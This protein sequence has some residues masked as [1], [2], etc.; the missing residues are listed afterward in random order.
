MDRN[1]PMPRSVFQEGFIHQ[2][3][4]P[5]YKTLNAVEGLDFSVQVQAFENMARHWVGD[6]SKPKPNKLKETRSFSL[7]KK[8]S[9]PA[10]AYKS[11]R[12][13]YENEVEEEYDETETKEMGNQGA[14]RSVSHDGTVQSS[15]SDVRHRLNLSP[16]AFLSEGQDHMDDI[17]NG[18]QRSAIRDAILRSRAAKASAFQPVMTTSFNRAFSS[19]LMS[20][21]LLASP[22]P[23]SDAQGARKAMM[24][25]EEEAE[26]YLATRRRKR[27]AG[28]PSTEKHQQ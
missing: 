13:M 5:L 21:P 18:V 23:P 14:I 27:P 16:R 10:D 4:L 20:S 26:D 25:E 11:M 19:Q 8:S 2:I 6:T 12:S 1:N 7:Q 24:R 17:I 3:C 22:A 15:K 28:E 9:L